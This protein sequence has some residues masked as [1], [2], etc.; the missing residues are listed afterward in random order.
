MRNYKT[1]TIEIDKKN[2]VSITCN[3]CNRTF[4]CRDDSFEV[5]EFHH[6]DFEGGYASVFG[7]GSYVTGD[8]CQHCMKEVFGDVL[9]IED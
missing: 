4:D 3:K 2:L 5:Q 6:I 9:Q 1:K 8:I 7:D